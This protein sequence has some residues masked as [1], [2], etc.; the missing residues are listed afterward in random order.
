[1][2]HRRF[3]D[4]DIHYNEITVPFAVS[5]IAVAKPCI[6]RSLIIYSDGTN[7]V[8]FNIYDNLAASGRK[9][10]PNGFLVLGATRTWTYSQDIL[11]LNGV[12]VEVTPADAGVTS[13]QVVYDV[14]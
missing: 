13:Y 3:K 2:G 14:G 7:N 6:F 5:A 4:H 12:Y 9:L 11:C 1:M 10:N 8:V